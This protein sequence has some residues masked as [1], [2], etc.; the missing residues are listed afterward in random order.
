V[1]KFGSHLFDDYWDEC[2]GE[3]FVLMGV[4]LYWQAYMELYVYS[5]T[6]PGCADFLYEWGR[7][8]LYED[9]ISDNG[10]ALTLSALLLLLIL[11]G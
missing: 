11:E 9:Y 8:D 2:D 6:M 10:L 4:W 7:K 5:K 3:E 1:P